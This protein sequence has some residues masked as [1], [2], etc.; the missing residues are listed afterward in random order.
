[1]SSDILFDRIGS[2]T[3]QALILPRE[4]NFEALSHFVVTF[5]FYI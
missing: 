2:V 4:W 5:F 1:M 3:K